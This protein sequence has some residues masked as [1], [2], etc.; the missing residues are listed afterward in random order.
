MVEVVRIEWMEADFMM[1]CGIESDDSWSHAHTITNA[2]LARD[3][4]FSFAHES[5]VATSNAF[6]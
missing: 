4:F 1:R 3:D 6:N 5:S 2:P